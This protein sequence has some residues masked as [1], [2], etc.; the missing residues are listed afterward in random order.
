MTMTP[1]EAEV[2]TMTPM[3]PEVT[4]LIGS[5]CRSS[6]VVVLGKHS[7][8][9]VLAHCDERPCE[10]TRFAGLAWLSQRRALL[11]SV[12]VGT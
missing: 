7:S 4:T 3:E 5:G 11:E 2:K 8:D 12:G 10:H 9:S 1:M 6:T